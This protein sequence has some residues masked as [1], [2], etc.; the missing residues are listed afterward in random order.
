MLNVIRDRFER[1]GNLLRCRNNKESRAKRTI[2]A[3][4]DFR[5]SRLTKNIFAD[6]DCQQSTELFRSCLEI[7]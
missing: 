1:V 3:K 4:R 6:S 5:H 7:M 2:H